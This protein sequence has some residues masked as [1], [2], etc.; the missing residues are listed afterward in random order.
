[1]TNRWRL[2]WA[3]PGP[4][5]LA[6]SSVAVESRPTRP[7]QPGSAPRDAPPDVPVAPARSECDPAEWST[8][9]RPGPQ[10]C[11]PAI[12]APIVAAAAVAA[13]PGEL[14]PRDA[15]TKVRPDGRRA[16]GESAGL[17]SGSRRSSSG[18]ADPQARGG[19]RR[20]LRAGRA[21]H[22]GAGLEPA[23][24]PSLRLP[25][26]C[27]RPPDPTLQGAPPTPETAQPAS[28]TVAPL[29]PK[30]QAS[31]TGGEDSARYLRCC[32][33]ADFAC[34]RCSGGFVLLGT[35]I[36]LAI[37]RSPSS[38]ASMIWIAAASEWGLVGRNLQLAIYAWTHSSL[39][40]SVVMGLRGV[41]PFLRGKRRATSFPSSC[42]GTELLHGGGG[43][44]PLS[45]RSGP[46]PTCCSIRNSARPETVYS[47]AAESRQPACGAV[48]HRGV[49]TPKRGP[50]HAPSLFTCWPESW[51]AFSCPI[52][53]M[54][55]PGDPARLR[56]P[57]PHPDKDVSHG[58]RTF[59]RHLVMEENRN[60]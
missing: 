19:A 13:T 41:T 31:L 37:A 10:E 11:R 28:V 46:G 60:L 18:R 14:G 33:P 43:G 36:R 23:P 24:L 57:A 52:R 50:F 40:M 32:R 5:G 8:R 21:S 59:Q 29:S 25:S 47:R 15:A 49:L 45:S 4:S 39:N 9:C 42:P 38:T 48:P 17:S 20:G 56:A 34:P 6:R 26:G 54:L 30:R 55:L 12:A 35:R 58:L 44:R 7:P 1:M 2:A 53:P 16:T 22:V 3:S 27:P 51:P